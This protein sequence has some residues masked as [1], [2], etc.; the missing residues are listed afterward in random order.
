MDRRAPRERAPPADGVLPEGD[1]NAKLRDGYQHTSLEGARKWVNGA[2]ERRD[3]AIESVPL[4]RW[5][6]ELVEVASH[7]GAD[8]FRGHLSYLVVD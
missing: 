6:D 5:N 7:D 3:R 1:W 4:E 8:H 2:F